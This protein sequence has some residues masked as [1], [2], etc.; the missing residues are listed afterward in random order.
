MRYGPELT[1]ATDIGASMW[2]VDTE[3][4]DE[5][6]E[7][8]VD[9]PDVEGYYKDFAE[10]YEQ[11]LRNWGYCIPDLTADAILEE[12]GHK[13]SLGEVSQT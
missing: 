7:K 2:F 13:K 5:F 6:A 8:L 12:G 4:T 1:E 9:C 10:N 3:T 11:V